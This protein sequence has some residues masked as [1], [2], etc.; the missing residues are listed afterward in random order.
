MSILYLKIRTGKFRKATRNE[1]LD[2]AGAYHV[3]ERVE[4]R[5]KLEGPKSAFQLCQ[6]LVGGREH[7]EFGILWFDA[8]YRLLGAERLFR[9]TIDGATVYPREVIKRCLE[10]GATAAA[11]THNHPSGISE[12]S[13]SDRAITLRLQRAFELIDVRL[14]D[15]LVLGANNSY[16]SLAEK[17]FI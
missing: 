15:H 8:R 9:G 17:G 1:V 7:E 2:V 14:I 12:P 13:E 10:V 4:E 11:L 5:M 3:E 6:A 16:T